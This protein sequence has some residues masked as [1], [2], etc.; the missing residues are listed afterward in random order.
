MLLTFHRKRKRFKR[1]IDPKP[2]RGIMSGRYWEMRINKYI[3]LWVI[4]IFL[5][6]WRI[7][8]YPDDSPYLFRFI[9]IAFIRSKWFLYFGII[10][11]PCTLFELFV[12]NPILNEIVWYIYDIMVLYKRYKRKLR[13]LMF[14]SHYGLYC[15]KWNRYKL[16]KLKTY[17]GGILKYYTSPLLNFYKKVLMYGRW[18]AFLKRRYVKRYNRA[19]YWRWVVNSVKF[20]YDKVALFPYYNDKFS[21]KL[22]KNRIVHASLS[23]YKRIGW[24]RTPRLK[25]VLRSGTKQIPDGIAF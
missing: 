18:F 13:K 22:I 8:R 19:F 5:C 7:K 21:Q 10:V 11:I 4:S 3:D 16:E 2:Y 14:D 25:R 24:K 17:L 1:I 23:P 20:Y 6:D 15:S 9:H 12:L